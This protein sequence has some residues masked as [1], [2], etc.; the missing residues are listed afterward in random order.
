MPCNGM[1]FL[2]L[3]L[4]AF[5]ILQR[6]ANICSKTMQSSSILSKSFGNQILRL[7]LAGCWKKSLLQ[8]ASDAS[9]CSPTVTAFAGTA[10]PSDGSLSLLCFEKPVKRWHFRKESCAILVPSETNRKLTAFSSLRSQAAT[11][12][13]VWMTGIFLSLSAAREAGC[14][15]AENIWNRQDSSKIYHGL[16]TT[17]M[18]LRRGKEHFFFN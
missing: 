14:R 7:H 3:H 5:Q 8:K 17:E 15:T 11:A 2:Q 6:R 9:L 12:R 4:K 16:E 10:A 1:S 13:T 18:C